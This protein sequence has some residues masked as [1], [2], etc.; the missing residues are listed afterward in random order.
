MDERRSALI[1]A[2][3]QYED[4]DLRQLVAP[5]QDAE[6]L[7]RV[8]GDQEV[9]GFD[10]KTLLDRPAREVSEVVERFFLDRTRDDLLLLYFQI[11]ARP[12]GRRRTALFRNGE[13]S[14]S[15]TSG[16]CSPGG[17]PSSSRM[18]SVT[19]LHFDRC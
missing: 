7:E 16:R 10:V 12:P 19:T 17:A 5:A 14:V 11:R 2:N 18:S 8:L 4:A 15:T 9:G 13:H 3:F 6:A 1:I